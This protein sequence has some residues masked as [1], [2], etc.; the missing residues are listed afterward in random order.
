[1]CS[2]PPSQLSSSLSH[3]WLYIYASFRI[4]MFSKCPLQ[5][6]FSDIFLLS[7]IELA[8]TGGWFYLLYMYL[9]IALPNLV[10][11]IYFSSLTADCTV[12]NIWKREKVRVRWVKIADS[13]GLGLLIVIIS[14]WK[15]KSEEF[16]K[17]MQGRAR[18][19]AASSTHF[20]LVTNTE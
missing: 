9:F 15:Y 13:P 4:S 3:T 14:H 11:S 2:Y 8:S 12:S 18:E 17:D 19:E 5:Y 7:I 6:I 1:M 10:F 16:G 20:H